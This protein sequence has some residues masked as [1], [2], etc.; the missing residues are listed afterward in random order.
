MK[1]YPIVL[2]IAGSD[3][4]GG[5]GIQADL[6]TISSLGCYGSTIITAVTS[7]NTLGVQDIYELPLDVIESQFKS[8]VNDLDVK[9]IK[10][11]ML[12]SN[13]IIDGVSRLLESKNIPYVLDTVMSA[14]DSTVLLEDVARNTLKKYLIPN[15]YLITPNIPEAEILLDMKISDLVSMKLACKKFDAKSVL[16]KGGHLDEDKLVDV[17]YSDGKFTTFYHEK[18][19]VQNTHGTGCTLASAITC[20]LA[21]GDNLEKACESAISYVQ[22]ALKYSYSTGRG[23]GSLNHFFSLGEESV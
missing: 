16:L 11:G 6:K 12:S 14:K 15:A 7:Q 2:S 21:L 5:A 17:L 3:S 18:L 13:K 9:F 8:V 22:N 4:S 23:R 19:E 1:N 10:I 20:N